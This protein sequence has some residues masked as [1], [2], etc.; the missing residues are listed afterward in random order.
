MKKSVVT[1]R[2]ASSLVASALIASTMTLLFGLSSICTAQ[3]SDILQHISLPDP[4][5]QF[6]KHNDSL[7][8]AL[9][10]RQTGRT[11]SEA[12]I[13][14]H[15]LSALL[16]SA[17]GVNRSNGKLTIPTSKNTQDMLVYIAK[18]DGVWLYN[19]QD[20]SLEQKSAV[21]I[22]PE[23]SP[24]L[25]RK[26]PVTF[27]YVND[28]EKASNGRSGDR[29]SGSMYQNVGLYC[30]IADLHNVVTGSFSKELEKLLN[31][32]PHHKIMITQSIGGKP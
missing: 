27:L 12:P 32:P 26:A 28:T 4:K 7:V 3:A 31:L 2:V 25:A 10:N 22:R 9:E 14:I 23:L 11:F 8:F 30:A 18:E 16:W 6:A 5:V 17:C 19:A 1:A 20:H 13:D 15:D 24:A 21:D 29:H